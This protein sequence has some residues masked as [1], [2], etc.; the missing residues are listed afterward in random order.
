MTREPSSFW[1]E[2]DERIHAQEEAIFTA[3]DLLLRHGFSCCETQ[4]MPHDELLALAELARED[5]DA[6]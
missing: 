1:D 5:E 3:R 6:L 4:S 2:T